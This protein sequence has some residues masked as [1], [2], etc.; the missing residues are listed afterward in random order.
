MI[1]PSETN[2]N[3][4]K[5]HGSV[6]KY[7]AV[8]LTDSEDLR[9]AQ[10]QPRRQGE[11]EEKSGNFPHGGPG[12]LTED[13]M[14]GGDRLCGRAGAPDEPWQRAAQVSSPIRPPRLS[15]AEGKSGEQESHKQNFSAQN[16]V[17]LMLYL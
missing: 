9:W 16:Q 11:K 15:A 13:A 1:V 4:P 12:E 10:T 2:I 6:R 5:T 14:R 3:A 17:R 7:I 8:A